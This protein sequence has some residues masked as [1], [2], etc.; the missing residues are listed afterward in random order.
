M[1][2]LTLSIN[3][4]GTMPAENVAALLSSAGVKVAPVQT[5]PAQS[6][7][8]PR[9]FA[10]GDTPVATPVVDAA[11][12][13][14]LSDDG[15]YATVSGTKV[16]RSDFAYAPSGSKPS[17]WK[18]PVHD[19]DHAQNALA[20]FN[21]TDLPADAKSGVRSKV[22]SAAHK[23]GIDTAGFEKEH[24]DKN[25]DAGPPATPDLGPRTEP[26]AAQ[27]ALAEA[28][29]APAT[30]DRAGHLFWLL[31]ELAA[32]QMDGK[33]VYELP[34]AMT[35]TWVKDGRRFS[36]TDEDLDD[37][38]RNFEGRGNG[39]TV[40]DYEHAS[41]QPEVARGGPVPAA[42]WHHKLAKKQITNKKGKLL[43][44]LTALIEFTPEAKR[45]LEAGEYKFFS[46]AI[47][48]DKHDKETGAAIGAY[49]NSG[50]L[51]NKPFLEDLPPIVLSDLVLSGLQ[52]VHV[53]S[54][55]AL[56]P[57]FS[58]GALAVPAAG[59]EMSEKETKKELKL[60]AKKMKAKKI[61]EG[62]DAGK[63][64]MYGEDGGI[65]K[66]F[67]SKKMND[68][69]ESMAEADRDAMCSEMCDMGDLKLGEPEMAAGV[70]GNIVGG[71]TVA[72]KALAASEVPAPA[73]AAP[74]AALPV[75]EIIP[76]APATPAAI[77]AKGIET[78]SEKKT[79]AVLLSEC[80][81]T[82]TGRLDVEKVVNLAAT[83]QITPAEASKATTLN[84][85]VASAV[86]KGIFTPKQFGTA[87]GW[88]L[89]DEAGF[90]SFVATA[91]PQIDLESHGVSLTNTQGQTHEQIARAATPEGAF[92]KLT[93]EIY[94]QGKAANP[95]YRYEDALLSA[96]RRDRAGFDNYR[97]ATVN[98][99]DRPKV[100]SLNLGERSVLQ[101]TLSESLGRVPLT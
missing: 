17:E 55:I 57:D 71:E 35:G 9:M 44:A 46:P 67:H 95:A 42:G 90:N 62:P 56:S 39:L 11:P 82:E 97:N 49:L 78:M 22:I 48:F 40:V 93:E 101:N 25:S 75:A 32:M 24:A 64:G 73:A 13:V 5:D 26:N 33:E 88:A 83:Q 47:Q 21:Q 92:L 89:K 31:S 3:V 20:R 28:T 59:K 12:L 96:S 65:V 77:P 81:N 4:S 10:P 19:K 27:V 69:L 45:M 86:Q 53:G 52:S 6:I 58:N 66:T 91:K 87:I 15:D 38:I 14:P 2:D 54:T 68:T 85:T 36:I 16:H 30:T 50:A 43:N 98:L 84:E 63:F 76:A 18:L 29:V 79:T 41:E 61:M 8:G 100:A 37:M 1:N 23:Y 60:M 34:I 7:V 80:M 51:T 72:P 74:V 99:T 70:G 94:T